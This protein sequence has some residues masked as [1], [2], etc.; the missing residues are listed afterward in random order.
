MRSIERW[1]TVSSF[2]TELE[3]T[4]GE[5]VH[6]LIHGTDGAGVPSPIRP[7]GTEPLESERPRVGIV[8]P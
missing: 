6:L 7:R 3:A 5:P 8:T 4:H 2:Q 1:E